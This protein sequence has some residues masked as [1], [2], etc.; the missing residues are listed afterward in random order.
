[1]AQVEIGRSLRESLSDVAR[2]WSAAE[3]GEPFTPVNKVVFVS[4]DVFAS[5]VTP[6]RRDLL[7]HLRKSPA[8]GL[9]PLARALNR[10]PSTVHGDVKALEAAGL[11]VVDDAGRISTDVD[12]IACA[13][14]V[15]A[16]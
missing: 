15:A 16:V 3:R 14:P 8:S 13:T 1:M 2:A 11:L 9:R 10:D 4:G 5:I 12:E 7:S 6:R